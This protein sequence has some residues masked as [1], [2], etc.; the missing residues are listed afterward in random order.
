MTPE[1]QRRLAELRAKRFAQMATVSAATTLSTTS[2][3]QTGPTPQPTA[4]DNAGHHSKKKRV[5]DAQTDTPLISAP[6]AQAP[7][8]PT[9]ITPR[10]TATTPSVSSVP[11]PLVKPTTKTSMKRAPVNLKSLVTY[12]FDYDKAIQPNDWSTMEPKPLVDAVYA[13]KITRTPD[14]EMLQYIIASFDRLDTDRVKAEQKLFEVAGV[15]LTN[16][17]VDLLWEERVSF[18]L[19]LTCYTL[20]F[21]YMTN[22]PQARDIW[23]DVEDDLSNFLFLLEDRRIISTILHHLTTLLDTAFSS[24]QASHKV[25]AFAKRLVKTSFARVKGADLSD[26][27]KLEGKLTV[28]QN[29]MKLSKTMGLALAEVLEEESKKADVVKASCLSSVL[30]IG[31]LGFP[32]SPTERNLFTSLQNYPQTSFTSILQVYATIRRTLSFATDILHQS[33]LQ[34]LRAGQ[35]DALCEWIAVAVEACG[36]VGVKSRRRDATGPNFAVNLCTVLVRMAKKLGEGGKGL[37]VQH[38]FVFGPRGK[39]CVGGGRRLVKG[40]KDSPAAMAKNDIKFT[41]ATE[42]F[43]LTQRSVHTCLTPRITDYRSLHQSLPYQHPDPKTLH[44]ETSL[45]SDLFRCQVMEP[46]MLEEVFGFFGV[47]LREFRG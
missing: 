31:L 7:T 37:S 3:A 20:L 26:H 4:S 24:P 9:P 19:T 23:S 40:S 16:S 8:I 35:K 21:G 6:V 47:E 17:L 25:L 39:G 45:L 5:D 1:E 44:L 41:F 14:W 13:T 11:K 10:S 22:N 2:S 42:L 34:V 18:G 38:R 27:Y 12:I 43:Y 29:V 33:F 36:K 30:G 15:K 46:E 28:I 32:A